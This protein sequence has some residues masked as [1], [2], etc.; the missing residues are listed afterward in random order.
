MAGRIYALTGK[1]G[2]GKSHWCRNHLCAGEAVVFNLDSL[3]KPLFEQTLERPEFR[4]KLEICRNYLYS[5]ADQ[6]L[7]A[8][9]PVVFDFGFWSREER[10][11]LKER[12][13]DIPQD[14]VY[15]PIDDEV[16]WERVEHRHHRE[17]ENYPFPRDLLQWLNGFFEEPETEEKVL[18][19]HQA[20]PI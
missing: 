1:I 19:S 4:E 13:P 8:G 3:M 16:Q 11:A 20:P 5:L 12:F 17:K 6:V 14:I 15:F 2:S 7:A 18:F 10:E 9:I